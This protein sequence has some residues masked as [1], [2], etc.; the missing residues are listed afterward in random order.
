MYLGSFAPSAQPSSTVVY[1]LKEVEFRG[2]KKRIV[3]HDLC[4]VYVPLV[5]VINYFILEK[6]F[7]LNLA[8]GVENISQ[9]ELVQDLIRILNEAK[10]NKLPENFDEFF[11][12]MNDMMVLPV[13]SFP[14]KFPTTLLHRSYINPFNTRWTDDFAPSTHITGFQYIKFPLHHGWIVDPAV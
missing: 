9:S 4:N 14:V 10:G 12:N 3:C 2:L 7:V 5:N 8:D 13:D 1:N 6:N 11:C